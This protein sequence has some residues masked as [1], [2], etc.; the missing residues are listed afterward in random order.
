MRNLLLVS[1]RGRSRLGQFFFLKFEIPRREDDE[2]SES[3]E[4]TMKADVGS[5]S[6][7]ELKVTGYSTTIKY[8]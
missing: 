3:D 8:V 6:N 4:K 5:G 7:A 2:N 1:G